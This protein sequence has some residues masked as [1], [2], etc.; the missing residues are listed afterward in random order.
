MNKKLKILDLVLG[1]VAFADIARNFVSQ[2]QDIGS[3]PY[4]MTAKL[5]SASVN[6][7]T[8]SIADC[9]TIP[10]LII[11]GTA[12]VLFASFREKKAGKT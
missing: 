7:V 1:V 3:A 10:G 11:I 5:I 4:S 2:W 6:S 9:F 12:I 8:R